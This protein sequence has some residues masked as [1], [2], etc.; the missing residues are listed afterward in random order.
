VSL[1]YRAYRASMDRLP[2]SAGAKLERSV[3]RSLRTWSGLTSSPVI[4]RLD[5]AMRPSLRSSWGGPMNGQAGRRAIVRDLLE[6][7]DV[8]LIAE[9]GTFRGTTTEFFA[10]VSGKPVHSVESNPRFHEFARRRLASLPD[11]HL[12][13]GDSRSFLRDL[14]GRPDLADR[15][16]LF[17]L[18]AHWEE[19]LPLRDEL[20]IIA[21]RWSRAV[22][23]VDDFAVPGDEGYTYDDY[24]PDMALV[25]EYLP[26]DALEGWGRFYPSLPSSE[27]TGF[28]RGCIVLASP[29]LD[30]AVSAVPSLRRAG[31]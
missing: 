9:T 15:T 27:E 14:A 31:S 22:A 29:E 1:A 28:R 5:F 26:A 12:V 13:L 21:D 7:L 6:A 24:G 4:G 23:I 25:E 8:D 16:V 19:D 18:D 17:Y 20:P 2:A 11:V 3:R 10:H 30:P